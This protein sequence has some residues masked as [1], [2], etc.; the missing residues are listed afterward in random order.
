MTGKPVSR[1][2][3]RLGILL[4]F[5]A[6]CFF[7]GWISLAP[8]DVSG[9]PAGSPI[10]AELTQALVK[11]GF[12]GRMREKLEAKLGRPLNQPLVELGRDLFFDEILA[13][14]NDN[15]CAG[16]HVPLFG[17]GDSQSIAIGVENNRV[18]GPGRAGPRNQRRT[19]TLTNVAFYPN[20][21][22]NSRFSAPTEDPFDNSQGFKFP[23]PE[24]PVKFPPH[25]STIKHLLAA[26]GH[27]PSTEQPEMAGF[28]TETVQLSLSRFGGKL[29]TVTSRA[30]VR[31][32]SAPDEKAVVPLSNTR[33][34]TAGVGD[35]L[36]PADSTNTRNEPIRLKVLQRLHASAAYRKKFEQAFPEVA[37][38]Q[39]I[40]FE[41]I[42]N[43]IAEFQFS[44]TFVDAPID[45]FMKGQ[46]DQLSLDEK[47][48]ALLF[49]GKAQC[50]Q[51]HAVAG[52]SNE[53]FS[54]FRT[55]NIGVPQ[56]SPD[57]GRGNVGFAGSA[58]DEDFGLEDITQ[59]KEDRYK[60]RTSPLRNVGL[61]PTFMHNGAFTSLSDAIRHHLDVRESVRTYDPKVAKIAPELSNRL[62][63]M[64]PVLER[65]S[66]LVAAPIQLSA[67]EMGQLVAF[68]GNGLTDSQMKNPADRCKLI[69][70]SVPSGRPLPR[71]EGC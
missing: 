54:D 63:P 67:D 64:R 27:I 38:G 30:L 53:M 46:T 2:V 60:F 58:E 59:S 37:A 3:R 29:T 23:H 16:C 55:H 39:A 13:L 35:V 12:T 33:V 14:S 9:Q 22:W 25:D 62:G 6:V 61:Q 17:F 32:G 5:S 51:C 11:F 28:N 71:F 65:L 4:S 70:A 44:L 18:V 7:L 47:K 20:L 57:K 68:V 1:V 21:M 66:P 8:R 69:P 50:W 26:Q 48:G 34:L 15:S 10:D 56:I 41:M 40:N 24:G 52:K 43:A 45:R 49:F 31:E 42:G 36:P 19:P